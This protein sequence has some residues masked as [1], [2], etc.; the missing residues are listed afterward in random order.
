VHSLL[1]N[2]SG[3]REDVRYGG[4]PWND[5]RGRGSFSFPESEDLKAF[6]SQSPA[7]LL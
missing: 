5:F 1:P 4:F 3:D 7:K 2:F 6:F